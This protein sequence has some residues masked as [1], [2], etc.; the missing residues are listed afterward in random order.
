MKKNDIQVKFV[1]LQ[2]KNFQCMIKKTN[3]IHSQK[4]KTKVGQ[5]KILKFCTVSLYYIHEWE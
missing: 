1:K 4:N 3:I 5:H 2:Q